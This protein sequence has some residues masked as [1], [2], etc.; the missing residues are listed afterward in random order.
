PIPGGRG[1]ITG[2]FDLKEALTLANVLE[3]PLEAPVHIVDQRSVDPSLGKDAIRS[4]VTAAIVGTAA[5]A[6]FMA[7]YYLFAGM[8]ANIALLLNIVILLG[9]MCSI[10]TTLTLPGIAGVVLTEH[11]T[12]RRM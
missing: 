5:V 11:I 7:I 10:G 8:V 3:N 6:A 12:P 4:G 1:Q 9:V 2:N